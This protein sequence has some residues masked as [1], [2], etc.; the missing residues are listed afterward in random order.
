MSEV[1]PES[2]A[3]EKVIFDEQTPIEAITTDTPSEQAES[4]PETFWGRLRKRW[5]PTSQERAEQ[6]AARLEALNQM[7]E[8]VPDSPTG[9]VLRGEL[10]LEARAYGPAYDDFSFALVLASEQVETADWGL[11]AQSMQDR[12]EMGLAQARQF[13][14]E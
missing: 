14:K 13:L 8:M 1:V 5:W 7:I 4:A 3:Q 9:Y 12:A 6:R 10:Y 2:D 11:V